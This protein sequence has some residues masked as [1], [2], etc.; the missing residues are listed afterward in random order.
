MRDMTDPRATCPE[1][2]ASVP[3]VG[4]RWLQV[5][6]E[7]SGEYAFP[8]PD[9]QWCSGSLLLADRDLESAHRLLPRGS[10]SR[11]LSGGDL[12]E[13]GTL[14]EV[15][16]PTMLRRHLPP[17]PTS[18]GEARRIVRRLLATAGQVDLIDPA[19]LLVSE[20]VT[21]AVLHAGTSIDLRC[22]LV[23]HSLL[24]EVDDRGGQLPSYR[25]YD[26]A[27]VCSGRGLV[28]LE[29]VAERW[30]VIPTFGGKTVWFLV[31][32]AQQHEELPGRS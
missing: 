27:T 26:D 32:A 17:H 4:E 12:G 31:S 2:G 21:N 22:T 19:E 29:Q 13:G 16:L 15:T 7:G 8:H 30:G 18:A 6:L 25:G 10:G 1:C 20:I 11:F 5:H 9:R 28:L 24:V 3:L 14:T 23:D